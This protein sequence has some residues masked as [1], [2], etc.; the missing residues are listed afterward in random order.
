[1]TTPL[2]SIGTLHL[3]GVAVP[4]EQKDDGLKPPAAGTLLKLLWPGVPPGDLHRGVAQQVFAAS[5]CA[6]KPP[7][8]RVSCCDAAGFVPITWLM[9]ATRPVMTDK[10]LNILEML[11]KENRRIL[12]GRYPPVGSLTWAR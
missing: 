12:G 2:S 10:L 4:D 6:A 7:E 5:L 9:R 3:V 11:K 1:M 8:A